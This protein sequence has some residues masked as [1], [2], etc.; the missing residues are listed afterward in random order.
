[1]KREIDSD[2]QMIPFYTIN[3]LTTTTIKMSTTTTKKVNDHSRLA[4]KREEARLVSL[5]SIFNIYDDDVFDEIT[6]SSFVYCHHHNKN[7]LMRHKYIEYI[8]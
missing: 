4:I 6:K 2:D 7:Y 8:I 5:D 3:S 1:M